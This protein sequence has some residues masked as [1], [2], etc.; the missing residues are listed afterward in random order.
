M[1]KLEQVRR[2]ER[3]YESPNAK[4]SRRV[5]VQNRLKVLCEK[6][7]NEMVALATGFTVNTLVQ[8]VRVKEAPPIS[9]SRITK[10]EEILADM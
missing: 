8:Y 9:D 4:D 10:A 3:E 1:N 7:G 2:K 5:D 6:H